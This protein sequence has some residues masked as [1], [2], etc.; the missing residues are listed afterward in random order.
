MATLKVKE[1][2]APVTTSTAT[3]KNETAAKKTPA[4]TTK[5]ATVKEPAKKEAPVK[6]APAKAADVKN[7]TKKTPAKKAAK[8]VPKKIVQ[9]EVFIQF[10]GYEVAETDVIE[11]V[12]AA[13]V[14]EG[15][16]AS[17]IKELNV[18]I[19]PEEYKAYYV[20]NGSAAGA[21]DL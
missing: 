19:K 14:A 20:I 4:P 1:L 13:Y 10:Q 21:V 11:K 5:T 2:S 8:K 15:N 7:A 17:G 9:T 12:K 18:Y 16:K 6:V 3:T